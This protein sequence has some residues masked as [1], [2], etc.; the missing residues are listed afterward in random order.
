MKYEGKRQALVDPSPPP[1]AAAACAR[2]RELLGHSPY[3]GDLMNKWAHFHNFKN[4]AM[5]TLGAILKVRETI[6]RQ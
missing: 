3:S 5:S 6:L 1:W 2:E 4:E